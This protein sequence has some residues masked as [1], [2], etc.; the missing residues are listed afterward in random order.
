MAKG[1]YH[2]DGKWYY[3]DGSAMLVQV[4]SSL[5]GK[6]ITLN[7]PEMLAHQEAAE[8]EKIDPM[9]IIVWK[10][11]PG[12]APVVFALFGGRTC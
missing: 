5:G 12:A 9:W 1:V 2:P 3:K 11:T 8:R 6:S 7:L 10:T 4:K